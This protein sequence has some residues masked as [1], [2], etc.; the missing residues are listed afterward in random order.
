[1]FAVIA[2]LLVFYFL[3]PFYQ[4]YAYLRP[5]RLRVSGSPPMGRGLNCRAVSFGSAD[6]LKLAAWYAASRNGAAV[7]LVHGYGGNRLAMLAHARMLAR[8]GY[9]VLLYDMRAHGN[10]EGRLFAGGRDAPADVLGAVSYLRRRMEVRPDRI[11]VLG[12][13]MGGQVALRASACAE[14]IR[15]VV[16]DGPGPVG[17]RDVIPPVTP[18]GWFYLPLQP[19]YGK[20][21]TWYTGVALPDPLIETISSIAPRPILLISTGRFREQRLVRRFYDAAKE[22]KSLWEIPEA[23]HASGWLA[24]PEAYAE[25]IVSFFDET[26][27][28]CDE[29]SREG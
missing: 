22:P 27:L 17:I 1:V 24:R 3:Y 14:E 13:S 26:L 10:S 2:F 19:I 20:A 8:S 11:G 28:A 4:V 25:K 12:V 16:A 29:F 5:P 15:A 18:L 21:L 6:G 9:G 23:I 7:I